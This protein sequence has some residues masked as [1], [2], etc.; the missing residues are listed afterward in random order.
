[1]VIKRFIN[2][3]LLI[4]SLFFIISYPLNATADEIPAPIATD[5]SLSSTEKLV[6]ESAV[7]VF[8]DGGHGSGSYVTID[9]FHIILTAQHVA[10]GQPGKK[11]R[12]H[13]PTTGESALGRLV[14]SDE[15]LDVA[16]LLIPN[17]STISPIEFR[18]RSRI[19][20]VGETILYSGYPSSHSLLSFRGTVAGY[21]KNGDIILIHTYGWFGCSGSILYDDKRRIV[22]VLW[23]VSVSSASPYQVIEDI[24][25]ATPAHLIDKRKIIR[26]ICETSLPQPD[27]CN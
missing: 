14:Y 4:I 3:I 21:E 2:N 26:G 7:K 18:P 12:I 9:Q 17:L 20:N 11:Y 13:I 5:I 27:A 25:W 10:D 22:G 16:A 24:I 6:R 1:M 8:S 23:G 19:I 15:S